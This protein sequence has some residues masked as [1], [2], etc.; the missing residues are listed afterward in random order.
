[1]EACDWNTWWR[2]QTQ[3][4]SVSPLGTSY[5]I[6]HTERVMHTPLGKH[7]LLNRVSVLGTTH[8]LD[9]LLGQ[10]GDSVK[11]QLQGPTWKSS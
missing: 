11:P 5:R 9:R 1:M 10:T 3:A 8:S 4:D 7:Q 2:M 6:G